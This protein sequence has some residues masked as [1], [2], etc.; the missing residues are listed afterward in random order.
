M[1]IET[2]KSIICDVRTITQK[3]WPSL[4]KRIKVKGDAPSHITLLNNSRD[5]FKAFLSIASLSL[6]ERLL[7]ETFKLGPMH[8]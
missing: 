6:H 4:E 2:D 8:L 3:T 7:C 5:R 1:A